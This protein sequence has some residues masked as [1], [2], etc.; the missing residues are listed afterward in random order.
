MFLR[1]GFSGKTVIEAKK[2]LLQGRTTF[3]CGYDEIL[4]KVITC[5]FR[6]HRGMGTFRQPNF[7][8]FFVTKSPN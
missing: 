6:G 7:W 3:Y 1:S 2:V 5:Y 8:H 4:F